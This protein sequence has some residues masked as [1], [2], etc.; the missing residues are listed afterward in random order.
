ME[1]RLVRPLENFSEFTLNLPPSKSLT[2]RALLCASLAEGES[3]V[4]NPLESEDPLLLKEALSATGVIFVEDREGYFI[5]GIRGKPLLRG[6]RVY[7]GNNGTGARFFLA[8]SCLGEGDFIEIYGKERLHE[9]PMGELISALRKLSANIECLQREGALPVRVH[10]SKLKSEKIRL[11]GNVSSQ[12]VSALLLIGPFL[13]EGLA[14][15]IE[16]ELLS[17]SYVDMTLEVMRKF[18]GEVEEEGSTYRAFPGKFSST[19][20]EVPADASS[21][22]YFLAIPLILGQGSVLISNYDYYTKQADSVFLDY[23]KEMGAVVEALT[24]LGVKVSF[25]GRPFGGKFNL[26]DC[27]DLFPTMAVL[28]AVAEGETLLF[29]AP[30][31]RYKET[32][33]IRAMAT[34]L[35]KVGVECEEL[36]DGLKIRGTTC[37]RSSL[38]N[39]YDDHRIAMSFAILGLRAGPLEIE[40]PGCVSKSFPEFWNLFDRLY[41]D[42]GS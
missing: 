30:H 38:I 2:Q 25:R 15:E 3:F 12:Y 13:P 35:K 33:R 1:T 22:S 37:F 40:N 9:R 36:P 17:K 14:V 21:A 5:R 41:G 32:D 18:G 20:Y 19:T 39:T 11:P 34:E 28:G 10:S 42:I 29:G 6:A 31:L 27:P 8:Y 24:P 23:I 4:K 7:L 16:G 26:R